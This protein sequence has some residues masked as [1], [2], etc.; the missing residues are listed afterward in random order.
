[1]DGEKER[2]MKNK[3]TLTLKYRLKLA[4]ATNKQILRWIRR[5]KNDLRNICSGNANSALCGPK[6]V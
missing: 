4:E 3:S 5:W 2:E 1:M 6:S